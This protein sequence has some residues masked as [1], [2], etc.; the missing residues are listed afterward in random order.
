MSVKNEGKDIEMVSK[1]DQGSD[2]EKGDEPEEEEESSSE[3]L[4]D[5][6]IDVPMFVFLWTYKPWHLF[7]HLIP[8]F[9]THSCLFCAFGVLLCNY[10]YAE[11]CCTWIGLCGFVSCILGMSKIQTFSFLLGESEILKDELTK[12]RKLMAKFE[13]ENQALKETLVKLE[14]QSEA[15][16]EQSGKLERFNTDLNLTTEYYETHVREFKRERLEL[17]Q[18]FFEIE[19]IVE[20]LTEKEGNLQQRCTILKKE[21]KKLRAHNKAIAETYNNLVEEHENVQLTNKRMG[22]Q[23]KKFQEMR[24]NFIDQRN[25]LK[26]SM[27]GNLSGLNSMMENYE[28][29][30]L[31]EI[32][33]NT[34]FLDGR[35]GMTAEKFEEFIR[36]IPA[37]MQVDEDKLISLFEELGNED[38]ICNHEQMRRIVVE[39]VKANSGMGG[40]LAAGGGQSQE[41]KVAIVDL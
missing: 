8:F 3:E 1:E 31:Q 17:A 14:E 39:I 22:E 25:V 40:R 34:E 5:R 30:Y 35:A 23:I 27:R 15:L 10:G 7:G 28:I 41:E 32:A 20:T 16:K 24:Q 26:D 13:N 36:R 6:E 11:S 21:L 19:Q 9:L 33:H 12:M 2:V 38:F 37:N 29:L 18:T 4:I